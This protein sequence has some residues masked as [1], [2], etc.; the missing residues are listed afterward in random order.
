MNRELRA[1]CNN[2]YELTNIV[3]GV[4]MALLTCAA[5]NRLA[6]DNKNEYRNL[7]AVDTIDRRRALRK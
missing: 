2:G 7:S 5:D 1:R 3:K 4:A 6:D